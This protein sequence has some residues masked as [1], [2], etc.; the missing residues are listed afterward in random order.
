MESSLR[1]PNF[2]HVI[3]DVGNAPALS[4][5]APQ[6]DASG[7]RRKARGAKTVRPGFRTDPSS[8]HRDWLEAERLNTGAKL[9]VKQKGPACKRGGRRA[10]WKTA[11]ETAHSDVVAEPGQVSEF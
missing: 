2:P 9:E 6:T 7:P 10:K 8:V 1:D 5:R 4:G 3:T 11:T